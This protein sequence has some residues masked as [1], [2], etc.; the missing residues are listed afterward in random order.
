M[1]EFPCRNCLYTKECGDNMRTEPC[2][3]RLI[4]SQLKGRRVCKNCMSFK[5]NGINNIGTYI[6]SNPES[7]NY[8]SWTGYENTCDC[9]SERGGILKCLVK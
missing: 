9:F 5:F 6:C 7:P 2:E 4:K 8:R 1:S 3:G